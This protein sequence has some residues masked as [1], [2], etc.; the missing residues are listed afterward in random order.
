M[1]T[2]SKMA[3]MQ[4]S[5]L[6]TGPDDSVKQVSH[7]HSYQK[8]RTVRNAT[9]DHIMHSSDNVSGEDAS[10]STD[11]FSVILQTSCGSLNP[12]PRSICSPQIETFQNGLEPLSLFASDIAHWFDK[13]LEHA[14]R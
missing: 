2:R 5:L 11:H 3:H 13:F 7:R 6:L 10:H 9:S 4:H 14:M 8:S 12:I 1:G